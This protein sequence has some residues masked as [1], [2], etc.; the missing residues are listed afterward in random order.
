M[1]SRGATPDVLEAIARRAAALIRRSAGEEAG[2]LAASLEQ[3][4]AA[5]SHLPAQ[6]LYGLLREAEHAVSKRYPSLAGRLRRWGY[7]V[8]RLA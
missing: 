3:F 2:E 6:D 8:E 4:D 1:T 7:R 5:E